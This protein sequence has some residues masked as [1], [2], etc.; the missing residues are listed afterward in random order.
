MLHNPDKSSTSHGNFWLD[1]NANNA[2]LNPL[3]MKSFLNT[4]KN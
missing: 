1:R 2:K 3:E 4:H